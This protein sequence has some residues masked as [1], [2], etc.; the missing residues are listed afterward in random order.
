MGQEEIRSLMEGF[1]TVI[2]II[3]L[4][5]FAVT[6]FAMANIAGTYDEQTKRIYEDEIKKRTA[7]DD[8]DFANNDSKLSE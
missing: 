5:G 2:V 8:S 6:A 3:A 4:L 7:S 1:A